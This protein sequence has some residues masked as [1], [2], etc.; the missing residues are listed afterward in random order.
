MYYLQ[1]NNIDSYCQIKNNSNSSAAQIGVYDLDLFLKYPSNTSSLLVQNLSGNNLFRNR[2]GGNV[3][4]LNGVYG[5]I[6]DRRLK[7]E[8]RPARTIILMI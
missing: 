8:I 4:N 3:S 5:T 6:S 2:S 1:S 7:R